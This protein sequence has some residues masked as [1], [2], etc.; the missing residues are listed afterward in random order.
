[1]VE[2]T[3]SFHEV[4]A[5]PQRLRV[6]ALFLAM[7]CGLTVANIYYSQ[8]ILAELAGAFDASQGTT[9]LIVTITQIGYALGLLLIVPLGDLLANRRLAVCLV[10]G[11]A[12]ALVAAAAAPSLPVFM[13]AALVIGSTSTVA[14][15]LVPF[16]AHL[17][18]AGREGRVV[19]Q[20]MSGL[21]L[22]ILL[23]RTTSSL[24]AAALSWRWVYGISAALMVA[25][26]VTALRVLPE[27]RPAPGPRYPALIASLVEL[28]RHEPVLRRRAFYQTLMFGAFSAFW[29]SIA[30]DLHERHGLGQVAIGVFALVGAG[31]A[32]AAPIAGRLG[33]LGRTRLGTG[34]GLLLA[35]GAMLLALVAESSVIAL[36]AAGLL[37]DFGVQATQVLGQREIYT[38]RPES[39]A[40]M[41]AVYLA[42]MFA[43]GAIGSALSGAIYDTHGWSG[44]AIFAGILPL[45]GFAHWLRTPTGR[46]A[47]IAA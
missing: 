23:A 20:V 7:A 30:Y 27:R 24:I 5:D 47:T 14:Q 1:M 38:T 44:V 41:N 17:A 12:V 36:A 4:R 39:R 19:G 34:A 11:T 40:R 45:I 35:A 28:V 25:V 42:T 37:L 18:P 32:A 6:V 46:V 15:V 43:G 29:T 8:P 3:A 9:A 10:S 31:G 13:A 26:A 22:G 21:L 33:D 2:S 16:A